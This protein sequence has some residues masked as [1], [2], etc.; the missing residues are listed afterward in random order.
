MVIVVIYSLTEKKSDKCK[1][2]NKNGNFPTPFCL[3]NISE[4]FDYIESEEISF[5]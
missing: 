1:A 2:D 3:G 5:K 4:K